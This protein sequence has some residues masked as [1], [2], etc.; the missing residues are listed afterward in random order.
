LLRV[1]PVDPGVEEWKPGQIF[2]RE[3]PPRT[4]TDLQAIVRTFEQKDRYDPEVWP[5]GEAYFIGKLRETYLGEL[6]D[7]VGEA[8]RR[9]P[10]TPEPSEVPEEAAETGS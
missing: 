8:L 4:E 3:L 2:A 1:H 9:L 5:S 6:L 7:T 10:S